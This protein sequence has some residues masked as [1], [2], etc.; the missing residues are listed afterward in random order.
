VDVSIRGLI[1][2]V[3]DGVPGVTGAVIATADGFVVASRLADGIPLD[4]AAIA[5]MSA[6]TLGLA[7][8]LVG[9]G[10]EQPATVSIQRSASVQVLVFA[11]G[12][13][14]ALTILATS[15]A[16]DAL[17]ERVGLEVSTGLRRAFDAP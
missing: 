17:L 7:T 2:S 13:A 11:V 6:A 9:L 3:V 8:R 1:D 15:T 12:T 14:A 16:D 4:P 10:G 5:A